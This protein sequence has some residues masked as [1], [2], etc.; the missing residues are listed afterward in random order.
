MEVDCAMVVA[1]QLLRKEITRNY[2]K[3]IMADGL[4]VSGSRSSLHNFGSDSSNLLSSLGV[5]FSFQEAWS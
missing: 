5:K 3:G 4:N 1:L 2:E